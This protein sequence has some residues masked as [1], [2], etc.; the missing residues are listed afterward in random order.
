LPKLCIQQLK[1]KAMKKTVLITGSS[2][3]F[4]KETAKLFQNNE[5]N[6]IAA[7][8]SPENE[9]ELSGLENVLVNNAGY[10]VIGAVEAASDAVIRRQFGVNLFGVIDVTR[11]VLPVMRKNKSG[12]IV[13]ISSMGG[14]ITIPFGSLY[15][16]S[17]FALEGLTEGMQYELNPLGIGLKLVEPGSYRTDFNGRSLDF[18]GS[19]DLND[20]RDMFAKFTVVAKQPGRGNANLSEV[21]ETIYKAA[22]D[23]SEQLRYPVGA[24]AITMIQ[25][26]L[27]KG[28]V[29]FK[30][31]IAGRFGI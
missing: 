12:I 3:G 26:K 28:D 22:T 1:L 20:Y 2:S 24:D 13:N 9:K 27:D 25:T 30:K 7:M 5:W 18:F 16:S 21:S 10:G 15:N 31:M 14:R 11:A 17:K 29:E 6:V 23:G 4:G 19:G 8:R